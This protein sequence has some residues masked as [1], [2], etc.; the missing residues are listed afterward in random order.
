VLPTKQA[1]LEAFGYVH[2]DALIEMAEE[3]DRVS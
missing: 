3:E 1:A 2:S